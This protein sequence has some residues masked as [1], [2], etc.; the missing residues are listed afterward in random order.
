MLH[1]F[2]E[3]SATQEKGIYLQ[4]V[5]RCVVNQQSNQPII[6]ESIRDAH[7][8]NFR[9]CRTPQVRHIRFRSPARCAIELVSALSEL[10]QARELFLLCGFDCDL[11]IQ[12]RHK[13]RQVD[14]F[15]HELVS[16]AILLI[17][18]R[19]VS[20]FSSDVQMVEYPKVLEPMRN[21]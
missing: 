19:A 3:H 14:G 21:E 5:C 18:G 4:R 16:H 9:C 11:K 12:A 15:S 17:H 13:I 1:S 20:V 6:A 2:A 10:S 8:Q 7:G